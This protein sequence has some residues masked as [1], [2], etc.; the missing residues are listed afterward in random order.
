VGERQL[1][2]KFTPAWFKRAECR[3]LDP[4]L[5]QPQHGGDPGAA[6]RVC[7]ECPVRQQC[8]EHGM[9]YRERGIWGGTT[10]RDRKRIRRKAS[11]QA[12]LQVA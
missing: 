3:G 9:E 12:K 7:A 1:F 8:F 10:E 5:F 6:L 2:P 11:R 4:D